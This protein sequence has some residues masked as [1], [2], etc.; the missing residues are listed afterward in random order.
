M[1]ELLRDI[2][3]IPA[4]SFNEEKRCTFLYE[5]LLQSG[6][7]STRV[8]NNLIALN[9]LFDPKKATL[10]LDAHIDT[11]APS[12]QYSR[13][14]YDTG[15]SN[16]I[17]YGLGSND[18]GGSVVTMIH[19]FRHYY[20]AEL[21]INLMLVLA[22][23]EERSG[24]GGAAQL[25]ASDGY[26][27]SKGLMPK[28]VIVGEPTGMQAA[29]SER[30]L[31]VIDG[32]ARGESAH[33]AHGIGINALYIALDDIQAIRQFRFERIS[34][35]MGEVRCNVTQ[36]SSGSAHNV[37]PDSCKF[38]VDIRP[39]DLYANSDI[40]SSL[41]SICKSKLTARNLSNKSSAT[42]AESLLIKTAKKLQINTF[43]SATTS[44]WMRIAVEAIKMGPGDTSR[45]HKADEY[46]LSK[47]LDEA[48]DTYIEFIKTFCDGYTLE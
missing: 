22:C 13:D 29:T 2:I 24:L 43:S 14:P 44:D 15:D 6:I 10:A 36:I 46:I 21:P 18:D 45:S 7:K 25:Y 42:P 1:I 26:F 19:T 27:Q 16:Q 47:E 20:N 34:P 8:G 32:E 38:V 17:I 12:D 39:T 40:L 35:T 28:W 3:R 48:L 31:L 30:G 41:Q 4:L 33:A 23:E 37:I 9:A 5:Y 11:V